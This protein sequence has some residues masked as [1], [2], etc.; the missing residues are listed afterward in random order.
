MPFTIYPILSSEGKPE[1]KVAEA[2][3]R[4][5]AAT[6]RHAAGPRV[7]APATATAH[8]RR[9]TIRTGGIGL[10]CAC[11]ITGTI[12]IIT[13]FPYVAAHIVDAQLVRRLG[14]YGVSC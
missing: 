2:V 11:V 4:V 7:V 1:P 9:P 6:K 8:A 13:P 12:P 3:R 5:V 14:G 10:R